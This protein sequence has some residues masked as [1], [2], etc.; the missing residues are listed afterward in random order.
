MLKM[1]EARRYDNVGAPET[2]CPMGDYQ[3][4]K[5]TGTYNVRAEPE[6]SAFNCLWVLDDGG[7]VVGINKAILGLLIT[8]GHLES[9][10][11]IFVAPSISPYAKSRASAY[12]S[13][14][15]FFTLGQTSYFIGHHMYV[16]RYTILAEVAVRELE[17]KYGCPRTHFPRILANVDPMARCMDL[18][19]GDTV[20]VDRL[21][22]TG[23]SS[24]AFYRYTTEG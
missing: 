22:H 1:F 17:H 12:V 13:H 19:A 16:P 15:E 20:Q 14:V 10:H 2:P 18:R 6:P 9:P 8:H 3:V 21:S 24:V 5:I 23:G 7:N 4:L 11:V